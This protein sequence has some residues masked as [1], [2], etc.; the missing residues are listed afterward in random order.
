M[1]DADR[2]SHIKWRRQC[3]IVFALKYRWQIIHG[4]YREYAPSFFHDDSWVA[5]GSGRLD[6]IGTPWG[7]ALY[8][9]VAFDLE[10]KPQIAVVPVNHTKE[11]HSPSAWR[12]S[13]AIPSWSWNGLDGKKAKVEVYSKAPVVE[14]YVN[15]EKVGK[16]KF[17]KNC[18]FNFSVIYKG[19]KIE[20]VAKDKDGKEAITESE[21]EPIVDV[22]V[23]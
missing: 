6:L 17:R 2:L 16:K 21:D 10:D 7:E 13:N 3:H 12:F 19:G 5:A 9:K 1:R 11:K 22:R 8:T 4:K 14:L 23:I 15:G 18:C 20:A